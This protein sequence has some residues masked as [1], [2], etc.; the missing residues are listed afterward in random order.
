MGALRSVL[1]LAMVGGWFVIGSPW[2][3]LYVAPRAWLDPERRGAVVSRY[4]KSMCGGILW[5][6]RVVGGASFRR[7]GRLPTESP[8]LVLMNHQSLLDICT[9]AV[10]SSAEVPAFVTRTRY[11]HFVPLVST[12]ARLLGSPFVDPARDPL[13][14]LRAIETGCREQQRSLLIFPE[15][16][17]SRDGKLRPFKTGGVQAALKGRRMPVYLVVNDGFWAGRRL[18]DFA[19]NVYRIRGVSEVLGPFDPPPA[20]ADVPAFVEGLRGKM[21]ERLAELRRDAAA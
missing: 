3:R 19:F 4:M 15:G 5:L 6:L 11:Q 21:L 20:D 12:T 14:A 16:H 13:A 2:L 7:I 17:R 8:I 9:V 10:M 1:G 18:L